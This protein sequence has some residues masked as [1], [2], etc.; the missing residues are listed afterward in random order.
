VHGTKISGIFEGLETPSQQPLTLALYCEWVRWASSRIHRLTVTSQCPNLLG[1]GQ[2][3]SMKICKVTE[4][5]VL[6]SC[7]LGLGLRATDMFS[8][9]AKLD[10]SDLT[11]FMCAFNPT[12]TMWLQYHI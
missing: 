1:L 5:W 2:M 12:H 9:P 6:G 4:I 11:E 8:H 3:S 7:P 10:S